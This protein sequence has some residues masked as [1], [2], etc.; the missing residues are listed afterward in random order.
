MLFTMSKAVNRKIDIFGSLAN[1]YIVMH[2]DN[3]YLYYT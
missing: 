1:L 2:N 3:N